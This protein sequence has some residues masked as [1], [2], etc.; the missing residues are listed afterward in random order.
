VITINSEMQVLLTWKQISEYSPQSVFLRHQAEGIV[1]NL[2]GSELEQQRQR[3]QLQNAFNGIAIN[4][5]VPEVIQELNL[6][7]ITDGIMRKLQALYL[8]TLCKKLAILQESALLS[9][10]ET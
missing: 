5:Q 9:P 8:P 4:C 6:L 7:E 1:V 10:K 3:P 2:E